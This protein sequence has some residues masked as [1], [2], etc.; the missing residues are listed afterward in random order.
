MHETRVIDG[1]PL[2]S[3][4]TV[5]VFYLGNNLV[6]TNLDKKI[7]LSLYGDDIINFLQEKYE[8]A[9]QHTNSINFKAIDPFS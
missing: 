3:E 9:E 5:I 4:G 2:P 7:Q 8:W 6:R 1:R